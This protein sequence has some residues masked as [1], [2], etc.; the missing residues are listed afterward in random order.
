M[1][2]SDISLTHSTCHVELH[3]LT[4]AFVKE[5]LLAHILPNAVLFVNDIIALLESTRVHV[6][7]ASISL[8]ELLPKLL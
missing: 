5:L 8:A 6:I 2:G 7:L 4:C 3:L 1:F